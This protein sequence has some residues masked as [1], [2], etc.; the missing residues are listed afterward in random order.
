MYLIFPPYTFMKD[1]CSVNQLGILGRRLIAQFSNRTL[2]RQFCAAVFQSSIFSIFNYRRN[3]SCLLW[4]C[5]PFERPEPLTFSRSMNAFRFL[6]IYSYVQITTF[7]PM[8]SLLHPLYKHT[9]HDLSIRSDEG[10]Y[11]RIFCFIIAQFTVEISHSTCS[12]PKFS[13]SG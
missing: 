8:A 10:L 9:I 4:V 11:A 13:F 1:V 3:K 5:A 6:V 2:T 12:I 7:P